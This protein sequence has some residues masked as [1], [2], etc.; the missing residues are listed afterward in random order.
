M[1]IGAR[2]ATSLDGIRHSKIDPRLRIARRGMDTT[3]TT[4]RWSLTINRSNRDRLPDLVMIAASFAKK[5]IASY[6]PP[7]RRFPGRGTLPD[8]HQQC[9]SMTLASGDWGVSPFIQGFCQTDSFCG[10]P[11]T[12]GHMLRSPREKRSCGL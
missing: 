12:K 8:H 4:L 2:V 11:S 3:Q 6:C 7:G 10:E 5:L 9:P 1:S